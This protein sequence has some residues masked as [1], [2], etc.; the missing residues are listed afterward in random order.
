VVLDV[1]DNG[2]GISA[3]ELRDPESAGLLGMRERAH[4]LGGELKISGIAGRGTRITVS[5]PCT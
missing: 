2:R 5:I 1:H 4:L 3:R